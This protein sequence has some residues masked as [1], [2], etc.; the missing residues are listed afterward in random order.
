MHSYLTT[1]KTTS[2]PYSFIYFVYI[3]D[4]LLRNLSIEWVGAVLT[5]TQ[6]IHFLDIGEGFILGHTMNTRVQVEHEIELD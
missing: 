4:L 1:S 2:L 6:A 3:S 5:T